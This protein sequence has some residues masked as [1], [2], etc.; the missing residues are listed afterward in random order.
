[1]EPNSIV[2]DAQYEA[3]QQKNRTIRKKIVLICLLLAVSLLILVGI[4]LVW[5]FLRKDPVEDPFG[6]YDFYPPY[7]GDILQNPAYLELNR[8]ICY[9]EDA[10]GM[11]LTAPLTEETLARA[12]ATVRFVYSYL[13]IIISGD[14]EAYNAMLGEEYLREHGAQSAFHPQM[15]YNITVYAYQTQTNADGSKTVTYRLDY[16]IYRN[17]GSFRRDIGSDA[18]RSQYLVLQCDQNGTIKIRD[19]VS[20]RVNSHV[21]QDLSNEHIQNINTDFERRII[22]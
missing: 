16:M 4:L 13:Q 2:S 9:C 5:E 22:V 15:L 18:I 10:T 6:E 21:G 12:D 14:T 8:E 11:G 3:L 20:F 7:E 1:M 19:L 17:D